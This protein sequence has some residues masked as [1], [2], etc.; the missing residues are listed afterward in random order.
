[1]KR[2]DIRQHSSSTNVPITSQKSDFISLSLSLSLLGF[3]CQISARADKDSTRQRLV[4]FLRSRMRNRAQ[5]HRATGWWWG[6]G[7][8]RGGAKKREVAARIETQFDPPPPPPPAE[9]GSPAGVH[10]T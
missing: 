3:L 7:E 5:V 1:V 2:A 6:G 9:V 8:N 4:A 10:L